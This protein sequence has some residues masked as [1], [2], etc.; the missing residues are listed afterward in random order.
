MAVYTSE[1]TRL[2]SVVEIM[3]KYS[4]NSIQ[5]H[6]ITLH[7]LVCFLYKITHACC[8]LLLTKR[9]RD[10]ILSL[11]S[12]SNQTLLSDKFQGVSTEAL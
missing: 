3:C 12:I 11:S 6:H 8:K 7:L 1:P 4:I 10:Y 9:K 2:Q 5:L